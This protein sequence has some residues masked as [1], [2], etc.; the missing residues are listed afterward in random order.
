MKTIIK[1][2]GVFLIAFG[3][4]AFIGVASAATTDAEALQPAET[5][6]H[7]EDLTVNGVGR[8]NSIVIGKQDVGGVTFFNGTI[9]NSTIGTGGSN[10]PVTFGDDVR[11][12][13]E[14][15]RSEKGGTNALKISDHLFPT[16][17][18][19]NNI[20]SATNKWAS[21]HTNDLYVYN[22]IKTDL[23]QD[24]D[25]GGA[26]KATAFVDQSVD[27]TS[28]TFTAVTRE[29]SSQGTSIT[30]SR[31]LAGAYVLDFGFDVS[32]RFVQMTGW[33]ASNISA[34]GSNF[35]GNNNRVH[36]DITRTTTGALTDGDFMVT[37]Y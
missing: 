36:V 35:G 25:K 15:Y 5:Y 1:M 6:T 33:G 30:C 37:I 27:C 11:I 2:F 24:R 12:D 23:K 29:F 10:N 22:N 7:N 28:G 16:A 32:D 14:I 31:S 34:A 20:G 19:I 3:V 13:G 21:V 18:D 4:F 9:V 26:V 17:T 8:F